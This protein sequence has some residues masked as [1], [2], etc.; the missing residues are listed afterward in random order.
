LQQVLLS[1]EKVS[2][3][4]FPVNYRVCDLLNVLENLIGLIHCFEL[5][6]FH[7]YQQLADL[8]NQLEEHRWR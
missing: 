4:H 3:Y 8:I 7:G 5:P 6:F 1:F 2:G